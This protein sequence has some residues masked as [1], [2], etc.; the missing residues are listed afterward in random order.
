MSSF[1]RYPGGKN[2]FKKTIID[3]ILLSD[4]CVY[5]E[6]FFGGGSIGLSLLDMNFDK[7]WFN[8]KDVG[9]Y[10]L[11]KSLLE[12][13]ETL[14]KYINEFIPTVDAFYT[15][16]EMF[17]N[18]TF[19]SSLNKEDTALLGFMKLA[20]HQISYSGLGVKSGGP[21]GGKNQKSIYSIDCRWSP[22]YLCKKIDNLN[23]KLSSNNV[24]ITNLDYSDILHQSEDSIVYLDP[25]YYEKGD[26]LYLHYFNEN[27]HVNLMNLLKIS[28]YDWVLSYDN[29]EYIRNIYDW[30]NIDILNANYTINTVTNKTEL[31]ISSIINR[32]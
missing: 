24:L 28:N 2:K 19:D 15:F 4:R 7:F 31:L 23:R 8:D 25:P 9:I 29:H 22:K 27:D 21:L 32:G 16:K 6:P 18:N 17:T 26:Q 5:V 13:P 3:K 30:S 20:I 11:W 1:F 10:A 12:S 14:K